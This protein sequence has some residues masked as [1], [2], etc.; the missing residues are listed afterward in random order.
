MIIRL[1]VSPLG[2]IFRAIGSTYAHDPLRG[3]YHGISLFAAVP[4]GHGDYPVIR[5][6]PHHH[7]SWFCQTTHSLYE[8][9]SFELL[10][11][12]MLMIPYGDTTMASV[13]LQLCLVVI[14]TILSSLSHHIFISLGFARLATALM[15]LYYP[16]HWS[17]PCSRSLVEYYYDISLP[18]AVSG[19][20]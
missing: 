16:S 12:S 17:C 15:G 5:V 13:S 4:S 19:D 11:L 7:Q 18:V 9:L 6:S 14:E 2:V 10:T 20:Q 8:A 3:Y 1:S